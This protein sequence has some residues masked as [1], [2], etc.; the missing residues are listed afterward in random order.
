MGPRYAGKLNPRMAFTKMLMLEIM[1]WKPNG[2]ELPEIIRNFSPNGDKNAIAWRA[3]P[4]YMTD[5]EIGLWR[6]GATLRSD[7][8]RANS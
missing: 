6:L 2:P 5:I 8:L 4:S 1:R 7:L 3:S